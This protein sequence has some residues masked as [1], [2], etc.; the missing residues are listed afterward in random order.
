MVTGSQPWVIDGPSNFMEASLRTRLPSSHFPALR[1]WGRQADPN[2]AHTQLRGDT[3]PKDKRRFRE[4]E[5]LKTSS[6]SRPRTEKSRGS[7]LR[8]A[9]WAFSSYLFSPNLDFQLRNFPSAD[10]SGWL[11]GTKETAHKVPPSLHPLGWP[12]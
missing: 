2:P 3:V 1:G 4:S 5:A 12:V 8:L 7:A 6:A 9:G 11:Q 10:L